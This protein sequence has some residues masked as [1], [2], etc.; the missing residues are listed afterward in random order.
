MFYK[1]VRFLLI[2][3]IGCVLLL[4]QQYQLYITS[5]LNYYELINVPSI[6]DIIAQ[7]KLKEEIRAKTIPPKCISDDAPI[8]KIDKET[9][10][11]LQ[12][13]FHSSGTHGTL[14]NNC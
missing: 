9:L 1:N 11:K 12:F 13:D 6:Y 10:Y 8:N 4:Q 7:D 3:A 2:V 5:K 14:I